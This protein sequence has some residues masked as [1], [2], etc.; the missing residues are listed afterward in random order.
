M[1]NLRTLVCRPAGIS[2]LLLPLSVALGRTTEPTERESSVNFQGQTLQATYIMSL[3]GRMEVESLQITR[4]IF[5][6]ARKYPAATSMNLKLRLN[7]SDADEKYNLRDQGMVDMDQIA[8]NDLAQ[9]RKCPSYQAL[10][11]SQYF[12]LPSRLQTG[13]ERLL[14]AAE[15]K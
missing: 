4:M 8:V 5:D 11:Y 15:N 13:L 2:V 14:K 9:V 6:L 10:Q 3:K 7:V 12:W 1:K